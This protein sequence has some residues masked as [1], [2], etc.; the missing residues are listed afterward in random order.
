MNHIS[1]ATP[2][3]L[4][5]MFF[6]FLDTLAAANNRRSCDGPVTI[7]E[8][9]RIEDYVR[10]EMGSNAAIGL[11]DTAARMAESM[12]SNALAG[13]DKTIRNLFGFNDWYMKTLYM[14]SLPTQWALIDAIVARCP[15]IFAEERVKQRD[16][17]IVELNRKIAN[18]TRQLEWLKNPE[19]PY[20]VAGS[21]DE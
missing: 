15:D 9:I 19:N 21:D 1:V 7:G 10:D 5:N 12:L 8:G 18:L 20:R 14:G 6:S 16:A 13:D 11:R 3:G 17:E 4:D 2:L